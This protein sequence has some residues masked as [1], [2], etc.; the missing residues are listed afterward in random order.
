[1]K[2]HFLKKRKKKHFFGIC[3]EHNCNVPVMFQSLLLTLESGF[4]GNV[5]IGEQ[6]S[7][8]TT[9]FRIK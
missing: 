2:L 6:N 9:T 3:L 8:S 4:E 1:M 7:S 5:Y